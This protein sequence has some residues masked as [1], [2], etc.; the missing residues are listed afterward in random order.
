MKDKIAIIT[1]GGCMA[2]IYSAGAILALAEKYNL[3]EPSIVIG[4]SGSSGTLAYYAAGQHESIRNIW[5]NLL[6]T[7]KFIN[8]LRLWKVIDIDYLIDV[9]FRKMDKLDMEKVYSSKTNLMIAATNYETGKVEYFSNKNKDNILEALK[10][11]KAIPLVYNKKVSI[12]GKSYFDGAISASVEVNAM[13]A[14]EMGAEK[15]V[16]I[17]NEAPNPLSKILFL[18]WFSSKK[19]NFR[20]NYLEFIGKKRNFRI[21]KG[22]KA[23][24]LRPKKLK[25][26]PLDNAPEILARAIKQGY[27]ETAN[28]K[29]LKAFL[30]R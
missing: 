5:S 17:D 15:L 3:K 9:I 28:N 12:N 24:F 21:P 13:K 2:C 7:K 4:N 30:G 23:I 14:I 11:S 26:K 6:S 16:I 8:K 25:I 1:S 29:R 27:D 10:A 22:V 19:R 18:L 20:K